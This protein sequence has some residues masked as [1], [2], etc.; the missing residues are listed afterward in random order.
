MTNDLMRILLIVVFSAGLW[1]QGTL[2]DYQRGVDFEK[3][4]RG[5]VVN[6]PSA[7]N[8]IGDSH[9]FWY[10]RAVKGGSEF[11]VV[12]AESAQKKP[13]FDHDRLAAAISSVTGRKW[14]GLNLP[15]TDQ[16]SRAASPLQ[17]LDQ[18]RSIQFG[19]GGSVYVCSL[20]D[21]SCTKR[22]AVSETTAEKPRPNPEGPGGDPVN[23]IAYEFPQ[24]ERGG[25]LPGLSREQSP[26]HGRG[27]GCPSFDGNWEA[28]IQNFNVYLKRAG[29]NDPPVALSSDG[30]EGNYY[31]LSSIAWSPD[32]TN[33]W[34]TIPVPAID[35]RSTTSNRRPP[36]RFSPNTPRFSTASPATRWTLPS[37]R[38]STRRP[39][40][41]RDRS[42]P[43]PKSVRHHRRPSGGKTAGAFTFEYNQ[44]GHQV[45][46]VIEVDANT[47]KI[48][49]LID[50][51]S[52]T[53]IYYNEL[54]PGLSAGRRYRHD[55][56]DGK[57]IIWASERDGWEHLY[58]Y[59]GVTGKVKNQITKGDWLVRNVVAVDDA[60]RQIW[61]Q[62]GGTISGQDPYF[63]Q[64]YRDQFR[65][66]RPHAAHRRRWRPQRRFSPDKKYYVDT[67]SRVD[68]PPQ[69]QLRR[70]RRSEGRHGPREGRC[71]G[72]PGRRLP[73]PR[74][75]RRQGP[76][77]Q[78]RYLGH[79][80]PAHEFRSQQE[81]SR[82]REHL[83]RS[84]RLLR[85]QNVQRRSGR[86]RPWPNSVSSWS[87]STAWAPA[88][89]P[90]PFTTWRGRISAT[91][92][93]PTAFCGTKPW[94]R[95]IRT[96]TS[97]RVGIFGTSA[98]GQNSLGALLFHPEFYKVGGDQQRVPR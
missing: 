23:G 84:A 21:Y 4:A 6:T 8:W 51:V 27:R 63:V 50:E 43:V 68:L 81:V 18:E 80:Y 76:R 38:C 53:F 90:R 15:L 97:R 47:A 60:K 2:A 20:T 92:A 41:N 67:W 94:R 44:R 24:A 88:I 40:G 1:A 89:A 86:L 10:A 33:W 87:R 28:F 11:V 13:A 31:T 75:L 57:E 74:S 39:K 98:G 19:T 82:D 17:F 65:R 91:P 26:C 59:D 55:L 73:L 58:L 32:S 56:D 79:H 42:R 45:Y 85:A 3:R 64:Y 16:R 36:A 93:S 49:A 95:S 48:R 30:S 69:S 54:G 35:R 7:I 96:T 52:K 70:R 22:G 78:D 77:R 34:P 12:D 5:L 37:P 66:H 72:A 29:A 61:F 25:P 46:R 14:S 71:L 62:A 83:C 9:H